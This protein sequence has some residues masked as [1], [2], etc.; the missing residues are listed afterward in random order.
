MKE[1]VVEEA[2][3]GS[4]PFLRVVVQYVLDQLDGVLARVLDQPRQT[5]REVLGEFEAQLLS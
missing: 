4:R 2:V 3:A 1:R 5:L